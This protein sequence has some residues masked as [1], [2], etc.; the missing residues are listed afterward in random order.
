MQPIISTKN[1]YL[2]RPYFKTVFASGCGCF[3]S[4]CAAYPN[5]FKRD[6]KDGND[7]MMHANHQQQLAAS[8]V[9][10]SADA[11]GDSSRE[12]RDAQINCAPTL[13]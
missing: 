5:F 3:Q 2:G 8:V 1:C 4:A 10:K 6:V 11:E 7:A 9:E 13:W 12:K